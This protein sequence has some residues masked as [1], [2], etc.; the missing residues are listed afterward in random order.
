MFLL[1]VNNKK[2]QMMDLTQ[3]KL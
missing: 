1:K 2:K 3:E